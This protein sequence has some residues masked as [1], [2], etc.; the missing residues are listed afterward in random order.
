MEDTVTKLEIRCP[1][2]QLEEGAKLPA[3][4]FQQNPW[5]VQGRR[6][7]THILALK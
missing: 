4:R 1:G 7:E 6:Q 2:H 5:S 3:H